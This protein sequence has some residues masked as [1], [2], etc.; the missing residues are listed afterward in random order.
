[1]RTTDAMDI[2]I[3]RT[4]APRAKREGPPRVNFSMLASDRSRS[5]P[6]R[7]AQQG[8][9]GSDARRVSL[10]RVYPIQ[11]SFDQ[12][13]EDAVQRQRTILVAEP[14][15]RLSGTWRDGLVAAIYTNVV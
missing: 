4:G 2:Q 1:M 3:Q 13:F 11:R 10:S 9:H 8:C 12:V 6:R 5:F 14:D 15:V 7:L